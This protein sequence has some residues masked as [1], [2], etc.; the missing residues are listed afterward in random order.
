VVS[1][2]D[3]DDPLAVT[4]PECSVR[5]RVVAERSGPTDPCQLFVCCI[6]CGARLDFT[7]RVG[8]VRSVSLAE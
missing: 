1:S 8:R 3:D 7:Q 2:N 5:L 6:S 4:C